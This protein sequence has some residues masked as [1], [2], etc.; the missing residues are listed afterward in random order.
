[1][2]AK[3]VQLLYSRISSWLSYGLFREGKDDLC[4]IPATGWAAVGDHKSRSDGRSPNDK[5]HAE[6][7]KYRVQDS[8]PLG[9]QV[10]IR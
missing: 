9:V 2:S 10:M 7:S 3:I 8:V 4:L 6:G 1:M 5:P